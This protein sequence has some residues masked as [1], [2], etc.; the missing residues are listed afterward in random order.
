MS[1]ALI[2]ANL[3]IG[4]LLLILSLV[5]KA[6]PPKNRNWIY[7][8]RTTRSMKSQESWDAS[9]KHS[10][11]LMIWIGI[12]TTVLQIILF[13]LFDPATA[14]ITACCI[15]CIL[16]VGSMFIIEKYLKENFDS[17]GKPKT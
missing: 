11:Q 14:L 2:I 12:I 16:L 5:F 3:A 10:L 17:E 1:T 6:F 13:L 8:Y 7:G 4:P 9:N 15:M